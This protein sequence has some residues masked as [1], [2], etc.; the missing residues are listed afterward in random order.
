MQVRDRFEWSTGNQHILNCSQ[1]DTNRG[2]NRHNWKLSPISVF[3][4]ATA[5]RETQNDQRLHPGKLL[6]WHSCCLC[7]A[8]CTGT[9]RAAGKIWWRPNGH[10]SCAARRGAADGSLESYP[11]PGRK[12]R[13]NVA[14]PCVSAR[15]DR[16]RNRL[17][18]TAKGAEK[19]NK[20]R[21]LVISQPERSD[22]V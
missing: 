14:A 16:N 18:R 10:R 17:R 5:I 15:Q 13:G 12:N 6:Q 19:A 21:L 2:K 4:K 22:L 3:V 8:L 20:V 1:I 7:C 11:Q 9:R